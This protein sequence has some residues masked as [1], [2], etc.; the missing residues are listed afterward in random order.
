MKSESRASRKPCLELVTAS[1]LP[2]P[3]MPPKKRKPLVWCPTTFKALITVRCGAAWGGLLK[4]ATFQECAAG[5]LLCRPLHSCNASPRSPA[6][7]WIHGA[8]WA[9]EGAALH[10]PCL[11]GSRFPRPPVLGP[12]PPHLVDGT[13]AWLWVPGRRPSARVPVTRPALRR[14]TTPA[15]AR[16]GTTSDPRCSPAPTGCRRPPASSG[17]TTCP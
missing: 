11:G 17:S 14:P 1:R 15:A 12:W 2:V 8:C 4:R 6:P 16:P 9:R 3:L 10:G 7:S 5:Q 13:M